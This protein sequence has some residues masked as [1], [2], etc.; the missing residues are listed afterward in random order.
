MQ[1]HFTLSYAGNQ[2]AKVTGDT[3][4][5]L[6]RAIN[7][8]RSIH[9]KTGS[10]RLCN[11]IV[12]EILCLQ[13]R[14]AQGKTILFYLRLGTCEQQI[15]GGLN[16]LHG[17]CRGG[18]AE[19]CDCWCIPLDADPTLNKFCRILTPILVVIDMYCLNQMCV[20]NWSARLRQLRT[21]RWWL[22]RTK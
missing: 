7:G 1:P 13:C 4:F 8:A 3:E 9:N 20:H 16:M 2:Y 15:V 14:Q 19:Y 11:S 5:L 22:M 17:I 21:L 10:E 6:Q 12:V 18:C